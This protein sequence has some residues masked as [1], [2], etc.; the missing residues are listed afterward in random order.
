MPR[1]CESWPPP[2]PLGG[3]SSA[4]STTAP[5]SAWSTP[6]CG[7]AWP[8][9]DCGTDAV[10]GQRLLAEM[11]EELLAALRE[12]RELARGIHPA[13]LSERG[14]RVAVEALAA[15]SPVPVEVDAV[16]DGRFAAGVEAAA[17][18][19]VAEA[20]TNVAKYAGDAC[21]AVRLSVEDDCLV[22]E[23]RDDGVGGADAGCGTGLTGLAD[24]VGAQGGALS[25]ASPAGVGTEIR[26]VIPL[27]GAA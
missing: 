17:Y 24:R 12:L 3:A 15:R 23:V 14:L 20:L 6:A 11:D 4:T 25:V 7:S 18:F 16:P 13:T 19:T 5:S 8:A 26:A 9:G 10:D 21:A 1:A 2:T 27:N 22:V